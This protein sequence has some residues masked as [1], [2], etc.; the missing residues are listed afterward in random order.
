ME[1]PTGDPEVIYLK[2]LCEEYY[3]LQFLVEQGN[4]H[5]QK[6]MEISQQADELVGKLYDARL[7]QYNSP[8]SEEELKSLNML[9]VRLVFC[10]YAEDAGIFCGHNMFHDFLKK[11]ADK[12]GSDYVALVRVIELEPTQLNQRCRL[13]AEAYIRYLSELTDRTDSC[14]TNAPINSSCLFLELR[15]TKSARNMILQLPS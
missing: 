5:V 1:R 15:P 3:R 8:A 12:S 9:C 2:N 10:L 7:K 4:A 6:E 13:G 11:K 14:V